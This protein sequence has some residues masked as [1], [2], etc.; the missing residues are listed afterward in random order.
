MA[1]AA[2]VAA[3]A[4]ELLAFVASVSLL[5]PKGSIDILA[6]IGQHL[7]TQEP[8]LLRPSEWTGEGNSLQ[9]SRLGMKLGELGV[10]ISDLDLAGLDNNVEGFWAGPGAI[11]LGRPEFRN[12]GV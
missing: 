6:L 11:F 9:K 3:S 4:P 12:H 5:K 1:A 8:P 10:V 2:L 7:A